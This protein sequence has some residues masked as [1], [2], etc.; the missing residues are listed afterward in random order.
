M[1]ALFVRRPDR[2]AILFSKAVIRDES[3]RFHA[4]MVSDPEPEHEMA[5]TSVMK[6][7]KKWQSRFSIILAGVAL[8]FMARSIF[9]PEP[10]SV[11]PLREFTEPL[12]SNSIRDL[13]ILSVEDDFE[14][15]FPFEF[16]QQDALSP[17]Q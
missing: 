13:P 11:P 16:P 5:Y 4:F 6:S 15:P 12:S 7:G 17:L 1:A 14:L 3:P 10:D 8:G 9:P 2:Q